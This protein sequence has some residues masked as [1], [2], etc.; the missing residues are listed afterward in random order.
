[1]HGQ[2]NIKLDPIVSRQHSLFLFRGQNV[3]EAMIL[4][5]DYPLAVSCAR[6]TQSTCMAVSSSASCGLVSCVS[7]RAVHW[8]TAAISLGHVTGLPD[9]LCLSTVG[10]LYLKLKVD[11]V[12]LEQ[13]FVQDSLTFPSYLCSAVASYYISLS[14]EM[15]HGFNWAARCYGLGH[16]RLCYRL[17]MLLDCRVGKFI[18]VSHS[19]VYCI[20]LCAWELFC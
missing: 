5:S 13:V 9:E 7:A 17:S 12:A 2:Q 6:R 20:V 16:G 8:P 11:R 15:Y 18:V 1:M 14:P 19:D 3:E 10:W 4:G